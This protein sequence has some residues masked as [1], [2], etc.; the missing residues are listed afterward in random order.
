MENS[1]GGLDI[2]FIWVSG[3][4]LPTRETGGQQE[5]QIF[6]KVILSD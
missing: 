6:I 2:V 4:S 5:K 1:F 3:S